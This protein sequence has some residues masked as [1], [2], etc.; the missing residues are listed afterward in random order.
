M[1]L[2]S[3]ATFR[4]FKMI[5]FDFCSLKL[6]D[7]NGAFSNVEQLKLLKLRFSQN[8][9][10]HTMWT[11][12]NS[13]CKWRQCGSAA[14]FIEKYPVSK[15]WTKDLLFWLHNTVEHWMKFKPFWFRFSAR[16]ILFTKGWDYKEERTSNVII[17]RKV[18]CPL[19]FVNCCHASA[20]YALI[21]VQL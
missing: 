4:R 15:N 10:S 18:H 2:N 6:N 13:D 16:F 7:E 1:K 21:P 11:L 8:V 17:R 14:L 3:H 20:S 19:W 12:E 5:N 9:P